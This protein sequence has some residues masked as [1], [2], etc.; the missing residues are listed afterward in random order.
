M[1]T[2]RDAAQVVL[3]HPTPE[4]L[5]DLQG[6]LLAAGQ[7]SG[8]VERALEIAGHFH[9]YL[10]QLQSKITARD[11]SELASRLDMGAVGAVAVENV[12][13]AEEA[14]FWKKF[15]VGALG[16]S[17]MVAASRQYVKAWDAETGVVYGCAAWTLTGILWRLSSDMQPKLD[18]GQRWAAIHTLLAPA[19]D[20]AVSA[21]LKAALLG[22]LFQLL[23][24][25]SLSPLFSE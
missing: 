7:A 13:A 11:F 18:A 23:L 16:E 8:A 22:R 5:V 6:A 24:L 2:L 9:S 20:P 19:H 10:C 15:V 3:A 4:A 21:P 25:L 14:N 12:I 17:L 1:K